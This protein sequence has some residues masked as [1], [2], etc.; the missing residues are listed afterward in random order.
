MEH[1]EKV[2]MYE[3]EAQG[4]KNE[5]EIKKVQFFL[6]FFLIGFFSLVC[7][8]GYISYKQTE[9]LN[10]HKRL[11]IAQQEQINQLIINAKHNKLRYEKKV[12]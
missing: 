1:R 4:F 9:R 5:I 6:N 10:E 3:I 7:I 12:K 8:Q 2:K 11:L